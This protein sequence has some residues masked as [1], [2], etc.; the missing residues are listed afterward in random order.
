VQKITAHSSA[1][2][3]RTA[4]GRG[5][6]ADNWQRQQSSSTSGSAGVNIGVASASVNA[7]HADASNAFAN[8]ANQFD[9]TSH[10]DHSSSATVTLEFFIAT[11]ERPW[12]LGDIFNI[13]GWY[14]VGQRKNSISDGTIANQIG[15]KATALLPM[16]PKGFLIV[17]NVTITCDDW[18]DTGAAFNSAMQNSSGSGQSSSNSVG[19]QASYLWYNASGKHDDQQSSGAFGSSDTASGFSFSSDGGKGGTLSLMGSQ[20]AGWIGEIQPAAPKIDD[21]TLPKLKPG[22]TSSD[23]HA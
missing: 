15:D 8:H 5:S 19:V 14:L 4:S 1:H 20:I 13:E 9:W 7:S 23:V 18:G 22:E 21:P 12:L 3:A 17:R 11:I 2:D 10:A 16:L 6:F